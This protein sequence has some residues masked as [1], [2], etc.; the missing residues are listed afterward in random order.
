M[1]VT[2]P[3]PAL[4]VSPLPQQP[5]FSFL[6]LLLESLEPLTSAKHTHSFEGSGS[7]HTDL[8]VEW[9]LT[10]LPWAPTR[11]HLP[12]WLCQ[13]QTWNCLLS[14]NSSEHSLCWSMFPIYFVTQRHL[15]KLLPLRFYDPLGC[16]ISTTSIRFIVRLSWGRTRV[17]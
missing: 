9:L 3:H 7:R 16:R 15:T 10:L 12:V 17:S 5:F 13:T 8:Q 14:H 4:H 2:W 6:F 1:N 11:E